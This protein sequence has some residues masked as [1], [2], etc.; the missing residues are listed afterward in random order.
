MTS[1]N[2]TPEAFR[3]TAEYYEILFD[4][5]QRL[6]REGPLLWDLLQRAPGMRAADLACGTGPHAK[7]L[8]DHGAQVSAFDVSEE[9]IAEAKSGRPHEA[10]T[11]ERGDMRTLTGGPW[12]LVLCLG[13]S[14]CLL[15]TLDDVE[16][17]FRC[18]C[19]R[20]VPGGLFLV[21]ILNYAHPTAK[22]ARHQ[23]LTKTAGEMEVTAVKNLVPHR[24]H[25]LLS[26]SFYAS[27]AGGYTSASETAV[28]LHLTQEELSRIA[29]VVGLDTVE[30]YGGYD[31]AAFILEESPDLLCL[32]MRP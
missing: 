19:E 9:M 2:T 29:T 1:Q 5:E 27:Q 24:G 28:L 3:S 11:Y 6:A 25:T 18:V 16:T 32:F 22:E 21:Q 20:L 17:T 8:A 4:S 12:D 13:N 14:L 31:R 15:P 30:V 26:L 23:V 7:F 10:I